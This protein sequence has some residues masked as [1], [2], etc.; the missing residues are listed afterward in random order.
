MSKS[1]LNLLVQISKALVN[2]KIKF[3]I[4]ENISSSLSAWLPLPAHSAFGPAGPVGLSPP[5]G[6]SPAH[7]ASQPL[8][9]RV[10]LAYFAEDVFFFD[11]RLPFS[12]SSLYSLADAWAPLVSSIFSTV[13]ADP[14]R[15]TT[16]SP[17][18]H[19]GMP[20]S[21]YRPHHSPLNPPS[22]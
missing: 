11:S 4:Q 5:A 16:T 9:P 20:P 3:L 2:S 6:R 18:P 22:N 21:H 17:A 14:G 19:L 8:S 10:P 12:A 1:L 15:V 7:L 13:P